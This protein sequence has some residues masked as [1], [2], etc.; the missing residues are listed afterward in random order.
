MI[1]II[2]G[3]FL[4]GPLMAIPFAMAASRRMPSPIGGSAEAV[5]IREREVFCT[6]PAEQVLAEQTVGGD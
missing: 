2:L 5:E 4:V 1:W 6:N 3:I